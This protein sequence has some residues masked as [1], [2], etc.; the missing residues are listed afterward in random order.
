MA[1]EFPHVDTRVS[2][3]QSIASTMSTSGTEYLLH[4]KV[5]SGESVAMAT[6][7]SLTT[8]ELIYNRVLTQS[9]NVKC[10]KYVNC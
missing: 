1:S 3:M 10:Y 7:D 8:I 6:L 4:M 5:E 2:A 9:C